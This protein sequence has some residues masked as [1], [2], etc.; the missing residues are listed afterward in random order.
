M[1]NPRFSKQLDNHQGNLNESGTKLDYKL[2]EDISMVRIKDIS[3]KNLDHRHINKELLGLLNE[4]KKHLKNSNFHKAEDCFREAMRYH[5][6][7][8]VEVMYLLGICS[9]HLENYHEAI[10]LL[11]SVL[12]KDDA[13]RKNVFFFLAIAYKRINDIESAVQILT[14]TIGKSPKNYEALLFRGKLFSREKKYL[15]AIADFNRCMVLHPTKV[16]PVVSKGDAL[17]GLMSLEEASELYSEA[18]SKYPEDSNIL[19]KRAHCHLELG[20]LELSRT[21]LDEILRLEP[22]HSEAFFFKGVIFYKC[23]NFNDALLSFEQA[24]KHN[25]SKKATT[26]A[27]YEIAKIKI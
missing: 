3:F 20:K 16:A 27:L 9:F 5:E 10:R 11:N 19:L 18:L 12:L 23:R 25:S 15:D 2:D 22:C 13:Y 6:G 14:I 26:K 24:I 17:R 7:N 21:D 8:S 4:G 1:A